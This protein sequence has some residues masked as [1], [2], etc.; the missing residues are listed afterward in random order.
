MRGKAHA[1]E[2][3]ESVVKFITETLEA[4]DQSSFLCGRKQLVSKIAQFLPFGKV[5]IFG[6]KHLTE[7]CELLRTNDW[8][9]LP[10]LQIIQ[11]T[12]QIYAMELQD[13]PNTEYVINYYLT[14]DDG[15]IYDLVEKMMESLHA[16]ESLQTLT[17]NFRRFQENFY[18]IKDFLWQNKTITNLQIVDRASSKVIE[19]LLKAV[20]FNSNIAHLKIQKFRGTQWT[21]NTCAQIGR[22]VKQSSSIRTFRVEGEFSTMEE[23]GYILPQALQNSKLE[24]LV[25]TQNKFT[26]LPEIER[27]LRPIQSLSEKMRI[28]TLSS[29]QMGPEEEQWLAKVLRGNQTLAYLDLSENSFHGIALG[30]A[31][32]QNTGIIELNLAKCKITSEGAHFMATALMYNK[33]LQ[34]LNLSNNMLG[35]EGGV[36]MGRSIGWNST[37]VS[38]NLSGNIINGNVMKCVATGLSANKSLT[39]L[40]LNSA[41]TLTWDECEVVGKIFSNALEQNSTIQKLVMQRKHADAIRNQTLCGQLKRRLNV[42]VQDPP[43]WDFLRQAF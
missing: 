21:T 18:P 4:L 33:T 5:Q 35:A 1:L 37:L 2:K 26:L 28:L 8:K 10:G 22:T 30:K 41:N 42:I 43:R 34:V 17:L 15:F 39:Y 7:F 13:I 12:S 38:L 36:Q 14:F 6:Q 29:L 20:E 11:T 23:M 24:E 32:L 27:L 40:D 19:P 25:M 16:F 31:L 9:N 3:N